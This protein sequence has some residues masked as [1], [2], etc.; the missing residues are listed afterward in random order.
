[1][2]VT[3]GTEHG[4]FGATSE[5]LDQRGL[6]HPGFTADQDHAPVPVARLA[7][8]FRKLGQRLFTLE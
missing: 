3:Q 5:G 6:P 8:V 7:H 1:M 2:R 4:R